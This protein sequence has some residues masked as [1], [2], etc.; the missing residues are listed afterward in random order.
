VMSST[1][2][3]ATWTPPSRVDAGAGDQWFPW[4]DVNP[5]NGSIGIL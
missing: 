1:N 4:V 2:G 5:A 3:G